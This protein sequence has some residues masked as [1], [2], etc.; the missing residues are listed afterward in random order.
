MWMKLGRGCLTL[1]I[2]LFSSVALSSGWGGECRLF[3]SGDARHELVMCDPPQLVAEW[4]AALSD[5]RHKCYVRY[6]SCKAH[7]HSTACE[8]KCADDYHACDAK[9]VD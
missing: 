6:E 5:C 8:N 9:C 3:P 2:G 1:A 7:C 4:Y